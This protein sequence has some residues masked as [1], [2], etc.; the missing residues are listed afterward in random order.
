[1]LPILGFRNDK[2]QRHSSLSSPTSSTDAMRI[3]LGCSWKIK[4]EHACHIFEI[5]TARNP[6][7]FVFG[8]SA[9]L[10]SMLRPDD[11]VLIGG[12]NDVVYILVKCFND[13]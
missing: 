8:S 3:R 6:I 11:F 12:N 5:D 7:L 1:M 10:S 9:L 4:I 2:G 13:V